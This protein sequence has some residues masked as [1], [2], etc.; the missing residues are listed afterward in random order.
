MGNRILVVEDYEQLRD[1]IGDLLREIGRYSADTAAD[2]RTAERLMV[3]QTFDLVVLDIG[4]PG[5]LSG[6]DIALL[7]RARFGC[8][9]LF[10][11]G[12]DF[13]ETYC[14]D[15]MQPPDR[16]LRKPFKME[17][18]LAAVGA[19]LRAG[20]AEQMKTER[21]RVRASPSSQCEAATL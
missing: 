20:A 16:L 10:I 5:I 14:A 15:F 17:V 19:M 21:T 18:L 9:I 12:H 2:G 13:P 8:P 7:A 3:E 11:T 6:R 4:L 1:L